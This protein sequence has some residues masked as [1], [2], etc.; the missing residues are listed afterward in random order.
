MGIAAIIAAALSA[1]GSLL[2]ALKGSGVNIGDIG[3]LALTDIE[4]TQVDEA[5]YLAGQAVVV[6]S[7]SFNNEPGTIVAVKNGG[8][9]AGSLGL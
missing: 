8:A 4:T 3:N 5:N 7:F 1:V 6:G 2:G 9:A